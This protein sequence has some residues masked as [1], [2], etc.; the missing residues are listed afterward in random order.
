MRFS[1]IESSWYDEDDVDD[2]DD[3]NDFDDFDADT[4]DENIIDSCSFLKQDRINM[5]IHIII[6]INKI[7]TIDINCMEYSI[8]KLLLI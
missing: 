2:S 6:N 5:I 1:K 3:S 7:I 8:F 4:D